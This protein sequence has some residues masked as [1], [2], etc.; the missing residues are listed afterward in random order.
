MQRSA[1]K[2]RGMEKIER[3]MADLEPGS[4]RYQ[5]LASARDFKASWIGLGQILYSVYKDKLYKEWGYMSFEA[6]CKTEAGIQQ[7]TASKLLHSYYFLERHEPE[8]LRAVHQEK[9]GVEPKGIPQLE[10]VN[11][12]RLAANNKELTEDDYQDFKKSVFEDG[13]DGKEV[14]KQVGLRMRSLREEEDPEK[15]RAQRRQQTLRRLLSTLK[16]L[17]KEA[18]YGR[19]VSD[20]TAK[21]LEKLCSSLDRELAESLDARY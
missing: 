17:Q 16:T 7:T 13:K 10:A 3:K 2:S 4:L 5:V 9:E 15:A 1:I 20:R 19:L 8:F 14:K 6:Y 11:V 12:L 21:E 18:V